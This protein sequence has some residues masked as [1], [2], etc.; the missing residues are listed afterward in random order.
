MGDYVTQGGSLQQAWIF[1]KSRGCN[2]Y[3]FL[4]LDCHEFD[5]SK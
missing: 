4:H 5:I 3:G 1:C 2:L